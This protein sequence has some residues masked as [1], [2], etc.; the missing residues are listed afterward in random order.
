MP[1][2]PPSGRR[3]SSRR[4]SDP[5]PPRRNRKRPPV[6]PAASCAAVRRPRIVPARPP[7]QPGGLLR[8]PLQR[9]RRGRRAARFAGRPAVATV[10]PSPACGGRK[11]SAPFPELEAATQGWN[12]SRVRKQIGPLRTVGSG[13]HAVFRQACADQMSRRDSPP[14]RPARCRRTRRSRTRAFSAVHDGQGVAAAVRRVEQRVV[15]APRRACVEHLD[16][17][18]IGHL[19]QRGAGPEPGEADEVVL[20]DGLAA[21]AL[22][23]MDE[24]WGGAKSGVEVAGA[25]ANVSLPAPPN[26]ASTPF[27]PMR[28]SRPAPPSRRSLPVPPASC[29]CPRRRGAGRRRHRRPAGRRRRRRT[30]RRRRRQRT[31]GRRRR[32]RRACRRAC[33]W[34]CDPGRHRRR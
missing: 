14:Y 12:G 10:L 11:R 20:G 8:D 4:R 34:R 28:R 22:E 19:R 23:V 21:G 24:V 6:R 15:A 13:R 27:P 33:R 29:R 2:T 16:D 25:E 26:S 3:T 9:P 31:A 1:P 5:F 32:H 30:A 7:S 17:G 18:R